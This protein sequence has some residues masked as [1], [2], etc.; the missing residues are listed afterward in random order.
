MG[1]DLLTKILLK[2][3]NKAAITDK[4]QMPV[5]LQVLHDKM[6]YLFSSL[7]MPTLCNWYV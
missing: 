3:I 1:I 2:L 6:D 5:L 4:Q 7:R